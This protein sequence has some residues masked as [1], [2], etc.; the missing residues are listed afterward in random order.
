[1]SLAPFKL[2]RFFAP[3]EFKARYLLGS[4]DCQSLSIRELLAYDPAA[5]EQFG[6]LWLGYT[7][8]TGS[9][10]LRA[11]I[12]KLYTR[13][14]PDQ[15]IVF[16]GAEEAVFVY[17]NAVLKPGDH[18][19]VH[20]PGY[21]SLY[22][23]AQANGCEVSLWLADESRGWSLD[24]DWLKDHLQPNTRAVIVNCPHNPTSY[25]MDAATQH[26]MIDLLR[27]RN[28]LFFSDEVYRGLE[29][30]PAVRLPA[31]C[32]LYGHATSL[33]VMSKTYGLA[34]LRIGWIATRDRA[35]YEQ[36][37]TFKDYTSICNSAPSEF[38]SIIALR[39]RDQIVA[40]NLGIIR[41]NL[42]LLDAF[43]AVR[44]AQFEWKRPRAGSIAFPRIKFDADIEQFCLDLVERQGVMLL[45]STCFFYGNQ[46]FRIGYGR[47]NMPEALAQFGDYL[48]T[49][50]S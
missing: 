48:D 19:I 31:A 13:I 22:S 39:Q 23:I 24:L 43:F 4:S 38:L 17:M 5:A 50:M 44:T 15:I 9:P 32:D 18:V 11:E 20:A 7:E 6:D 49:Y 27:E 33:G 28:I 12:S 47:S 25:L 3:Y 36:M 40:R 29:H 16:A 2:E 37:A 34:G 35:L 45:P 42:D 1:M 8:Y 41:Q 46:H 21:Q 26:E 10:E 14:D 30:D